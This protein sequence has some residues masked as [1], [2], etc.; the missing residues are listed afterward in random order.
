M[1]DSYSTYFRGD[2]LEDIG[3]NKFIWLRIPKLKSL[4]KVRLHRPLPKDAKIGKITISKTS[5]NKYYVAFTITYYT[6]IKAVPKDIVKNLCLGLDYSQE[7]GCVSSDTTINIDGF[8]KPYRKQEERLKKLNSILSNKKYGSNNYYKL[9]SKIQKLHI[10]MANTRKDNLHKLSH[11]LS[12]R[13]L[14]I[15]VEDIDLRSM[16]QC[17]RLGKNLYD[18]GFGMFREMLQ[19]K[20]EE[21]GHYFIKID[22]WAKSSQ[23]CN[24]CGFVNNV[25]KNLK[26]KEYTCPA[27]GSYLL[28]DYNAACNIRDFGVVSISN[29]T[30]KHSKH[31]L[32]NMR[33]AKQGLG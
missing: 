17:L 16:S 30:I 8:Q 6:N 5:D 24:H 29:Y 3:S 12:C 33:K 26:I 7:Y 14:L 19:Y 4:I 28:R 25:T 32:E 2:V 9:L 31:T 21:Q 22:K 1:N 13:F 27:C 23:I 11:F 15:S 10:K 18:N 20:Q